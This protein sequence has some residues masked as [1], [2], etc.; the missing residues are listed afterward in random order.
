[1]R[2]SGDL[3]ASN[4]R[5]ILSL[6]V[7]SKYFRVGDYSLVRFG[8]DIIIKHSSGEGGVFNIDELEKVISDFYRE[9]F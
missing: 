6:S 4:Q 1:M 9:K 5:E 2:S 7:E 3:L 8:N